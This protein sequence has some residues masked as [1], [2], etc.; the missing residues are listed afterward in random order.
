VELLFG[1]ERHELV[2]QPIEVLLPERFRSVHRAHR[3]AYT[4]QPRLRPMGA[5]MVLFGYRSDGA[6]FPVEISLSPLPTGGE[7]RVI[8]AVRD[9]SERLLAEAESREIQRVLDATRDAVLMFD[10]DTFVFTYVNQGAIDQLGYSRDELLAMTPMHIKPDVTEADYRALAKT[11]APGQSHTY[12][13]VHRRKDGTDLSVEAVLQRPPEDPAGSGWLVSIARDLTERLEIERRAQEAERDVAVLEDRQRIARDRRL[14]RSRRAQ[15]PQP[16]RRP[17]RQRGV[18]ADR[19]GADGVGPTDPPLRRAPDQG[20]TLQAGDHPLPQA[21]RRPGALPAPRGPID[22][23]TADRSFIPDRSGMPFLSRVEGG[24]RPYRSAVL[25]PHNEP[26]GGCSEW[27][28]GRFY[29]CGARVAPRSNWWQRPCAT[30]TVES[31][32][33]TSSG[34][35]FQRNPERRRQPHHRERRRWR[36]RLS[37]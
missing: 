14:L 4:D 28:A 10:P 23:L 15:A 5:G 8:A 26:R 27:G 6:E 29:S 30:G 7:R 19:D 18:V 11:L 24:E 9:V 35:A 20:G 33:I 3:S 36:G 17:P 16:R 13:T 31:G 37:S 2:G 32:L 21:L 34:S 12:V 22:G 25:S 1:Y